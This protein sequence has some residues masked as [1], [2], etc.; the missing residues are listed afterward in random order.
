MYAA[1]TSLLIRTQHLRLPRYN[2]GQGFGGILFP[3]YSESF[4]RKKLYISSTVLYAVVCLLTATI[5][6]LAAVIIG[7]FCAGF[8]SAIPSIIVAG[9]IEDLFDTETRVWIVFAWST[10]TNLGLAAGAIMGTY[11]CSSIGW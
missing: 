1:D 11:T 9:S 7:R 8:A 3:P 5:P 4:G 6:S 10:A 2:F